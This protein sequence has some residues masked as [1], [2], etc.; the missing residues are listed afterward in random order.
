MNTPA[1]NCKF[2]N[3]LATSVRYYNSTYIHCGT[4]AITDTTLDY[5]VAVTLNGI[6]YLYFIDKTTNQPYKLVFTGPI[7]VISLDPILAF[8]NM[9]NV[10]V[11]VLAE[12]IINLP[13]LSCK[14]HDYI[15]PGVYFE[16]NGLTY[17]QC[18]I[19]SLDYLRLAKVNPIAYDDS[20]IIEVSNN[21]KDFSKSGKRFKFITNDQLLKVYPTTGPEVGGT[22]IDI[23]IVDL[24]YVK[25]I[26]G[27]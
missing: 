7:A 5:P 11:I 9:L 18:V 23:F 3:L 10:E 1:L 14:I 27:D 13:S 20:F 2:G 17:V 12:G 15:G 16:E 25:G 4:P 6:E 8:S 24:P 22:V 19:P 26:S 21:G